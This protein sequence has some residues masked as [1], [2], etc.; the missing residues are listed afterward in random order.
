[1]REGVKNGIVSTRQIIK[2]EK[3]ELKKRASEI[4]DKI[5]KAPEIERQMAEVMRQQEIK[6]ELYLFVRKRT[7]NS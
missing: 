7:C 6:N 2:H 4:D 5:N 1:M 3:G